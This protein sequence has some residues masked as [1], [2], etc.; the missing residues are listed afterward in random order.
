MRWPE[1][2][3]YLLVA[4]LVAVLLV[5]VAAPLVAVVAVS[6]FHYDNFTI[7]PAFSLENYLHIITTPLTYQLY[8]S[9][10]WFSL[11]TWV[12]TLLIGFTIAYFLVFHVRNP[13]IGI[14]LFLVCTV[15]FWTSNIIRMISWLPLLRL[16]LPVPLSAARSQSRCRKSRSATWPR[17]WFF[18]PPASCLAPS[19]IS[20]TRGPGTILPHPVSA[21][22]IC[23]RR[24][25]SCRR[26]VDYCQVARL[27]RS[28]TARIVP[29]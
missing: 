7:I 13:L 24:S 15:P 10:I 22:S 16:A 17:P 3:S 14:G 19:F 9:M 27:A 8:L 29:P 18:Q 21:P 4:P 5:F 23:R 25:S 6:F 20:A 1:L 2:M 26:R 28:E 12:F 11:L